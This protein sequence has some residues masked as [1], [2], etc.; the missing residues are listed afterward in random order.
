MI[1]RIL[2]VAVV[3][4]FAAAAA[5]FVLARRAPA[6]QEAHRGEAI[7]MTAADEPGEARDGERY[8]NGGWR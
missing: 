6:G 4:A 1:D 8:V 3:L 5:A 7:A 2:A